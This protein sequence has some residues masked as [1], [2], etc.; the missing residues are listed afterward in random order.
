MSMDGNEWT[1]AKQGLTRKILC[2]D[3]ASALD[4][5]SKVAACAEVEQHHPDIHFGWGFVEIV[6]FT[7]SE[8]AITK[9]DYDLANKI[10]ALI[11]PAN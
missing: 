3:F 8:K 10:D 2:S 6:L 5:V 11:D 1:I 7:H 9:K 4:L